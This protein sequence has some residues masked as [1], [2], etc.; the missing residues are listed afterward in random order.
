MDAE[1]SFA[2]MG[3]GGAQCSV[4]VVFNEPKKT[5]ARSAAKFHYYIRRGPCFSVAG[6]SKLPFV[7]AT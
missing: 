7:S 5:D 1:R 4:L 6:F 2:A 3:M